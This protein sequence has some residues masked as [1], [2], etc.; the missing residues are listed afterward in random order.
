MT[1]TIGSQSHCCK[2]MAYHLSEGEVA[3][4]YSLKFREYGI[5]YLD[6]GSATQL[7]HYCPWCG[8]RLPESLR[9]KW[10]DEVFALGLEP[11]DPRLP[12][13]YKSDEWYKNKDM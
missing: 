1:N 13:Q 5:R 7:I 9:D 11:G 6:G 10:F 12:E 4:T 3:V 8:A 2:E